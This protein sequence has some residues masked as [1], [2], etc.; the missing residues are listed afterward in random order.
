MA[1]VGYDLSA[2]APKQVRDLPL[3]RFDAVASMGYQDAA[4]TLPAVWRETWAIPD[5]QHLPAEPFRAVRNLIGWRVYDMLL[6]LG[7]K[8]DRSVLLPWRG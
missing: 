6:E 2:H 7:I 8:P 4:P 1:E 5:S 3:V